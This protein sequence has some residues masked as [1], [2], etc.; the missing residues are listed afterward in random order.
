MRGSVDIEGCRFVPGYRRIHT[1]LG[2][3]KIRLL[4]GSP[5]KKGSNMFV[6]TFTVV[7][8]FPENGPRPILQASKQHVLRLG[9]TAARALLV[10]SE[11]RDLAEL[12]VSGTILLYAK[13]A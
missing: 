2:I 5:Y 8:E 12:A 3:P 13:G 1:V 10:H 11:P 7:E 6:E 9:D 4:F